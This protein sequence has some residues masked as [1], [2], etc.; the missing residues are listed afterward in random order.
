[1]N[2]VNLSATLAYLL[3]E[4]HPI[5]ET[6]Q[7]DFENSATGGGRMQMKKLLHMWRQTRLPSVL[8]E[9]LSIHI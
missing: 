2:G 7:C 1:M 8:G 9:I 6:F 3:E 5:L 4:E